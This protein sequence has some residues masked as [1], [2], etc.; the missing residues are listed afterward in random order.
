MPTRTR[1]RSPSQE[2]VVSRTYRPTLPKVSAAKR[3]LGADTATEMIEQALD[4]VVFQRK[5]IDGT[6][7]M[8]GVEIT[9]PDDERDPH[10]SQVQPRDA[11]K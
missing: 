4:V 9:F 1:K 6:R 2:Q 3:L 10:I 8:Q 5:L 7:S 11:R